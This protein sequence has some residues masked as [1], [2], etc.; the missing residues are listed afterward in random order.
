MVRLQRVMAEAGVASRRECEAIIE[1]G[2]VE[3]NGETVSS[4]PAFVRPGKDRITVDGAVVAAG[5]P[6]GASGARSSRVYVMLNKPDNVLGTTRDESPHAEGGRRTVLD[7]VKHPSGA[8][9]F[10]V[11]RLG[12]HAT[13]LVILTNDGELAER[14]THARYNVPKVFRI[15]ARESMGP[16]ILDMLRRRVGQRDAVDALGRPTGGVRVVGG[17]SDDDD[18]ESAPARGPSR[19]GPRPGQRDAQASRPATS[20]TV[21]EVTVRPGRAEPIDEMLGLA[22][23][24][25]KRFSRVAIGPLRLMGVGPGDWR[26]L[27]RDEV[28]SLRE[29]CGLTRHGAKEKRPAPAPSTPRAEPVETDA[30]KTGIGEEGG[31]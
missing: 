13:G 9:L 1:A 16:E 26:D 15:E 27:T 7:L 8:R 31:A 21:I 20:G 4:L 12:Y 3:V 22:G 14:L 18:Q 30:G 5:R 2:R 29:A 24:R 10:P 19:F 28:E 25:I 17:A 6:K 23:V 11:G